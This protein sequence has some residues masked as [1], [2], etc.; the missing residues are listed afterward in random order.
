MVAWAVRQALSLVELVSAE[1]GDM[2]LWE[3]ERDWWHRSRAH[4]CHSD[5]LCP[6]DLGL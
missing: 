6:C 2:A 5:A 4:S 3:W 1:R